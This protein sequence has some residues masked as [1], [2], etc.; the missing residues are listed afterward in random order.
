MCFP[1]LLAAHI[2]AVAYQSAD[3]PTSDVKLTNTITQIVCLSFVNIIKTLD[4][5]SLSDHA[6]EDSSW[7]LGFMTEHII[8]VRFCQPLTTV[9]KPFCVY[10]YRLTE[11]TRQ[12]VAY[13]LMRHC[14]RTEML[15]SALGWPISVVLDSLFHQVRDTFRDRDPDDKA[16][17]PS[18]L[19]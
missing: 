16:V 10:K 9:S 17:D 4:V 11:C 12:K 18:M 14:S 5:S 1:E 6:E 2:V 3:V 7:R 15:V 8:C 19:C 13:L